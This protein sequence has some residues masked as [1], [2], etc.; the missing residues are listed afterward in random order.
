MRAGRQ[1]NDMIT[2]TLYIS[3]LLLLLISSRTEAALTGDWVLA[4]GTAVVRIEAAGAT[5]TAR[6][7]GL[8]RPEF[9]VIDSQGAAGAPRLDIHNP[10]RTLRNRPLQGMEIAFDLH[11]EGEQLKGR[12]YDPNS[13]K[14]YRCR[15]KPLNH[16]YLEVRGYVGISALG[17]NMYWQ[18]L[19]SYRDHMTTMLGRSASLKNHNP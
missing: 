6:I 15:M 19:E 4:D 16:E 11:L 13:G 17:R 14:T 5:Y 1:D 7:I 9:V 3:T 12:I 10:D 2:R 18:R 8:L